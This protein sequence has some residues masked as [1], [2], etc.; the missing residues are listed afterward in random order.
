MALA[1]TDQIGAVSGDGHGSGAF[2]TSSFTP[3]DNSLLVVC[4][5]AMETGT[6]SA[7][8]DAALTMA[9]GG[10]TFTP[11]VNA[12]VGA[13]FPIASVMWT[14]PI[15]TGASMTL[16]LDAGTR[17]LQ[18]AGI[19]AVAYTGY[20]TGTPTGVT[21]TATDA[22]TPDGPHSITLSGAPATGS[23]VVGSITLDKESVGCTPGSTFS[24]LYDLQVGATG[25]LETEVRT[26]SASTTVDWVDT[27]TGT[28]S[29]FKISAVALEI[30][31]AAGAAAADAGL[32]IQPWYH[33][34]FHWP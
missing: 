25:G 7:G 21:G 31:A 2:T 4:G 34:I 11:R 19:T 13:M 18:F 6:G 27:H 29:V 32:T 8:L 14:A 30:K 24:E 15:T 23:E 17:N 9:G 10:L 20:D 3:P 12:E 33:P 5:A 26:G 28:G 16:S 22:V 1:R